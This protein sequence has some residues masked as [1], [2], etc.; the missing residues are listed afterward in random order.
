MKIVPKKWISIILIMTLIMGLASSA[1]PAHVAKALADTQAPTA[2]TNPGSLWRTSDAVHL[3]WTPSTDDTG[4]AAYDIYDGAALVGSTPNGS[5]HYWVTGLAGGSHSFTVKARDAAGNTSAASPS[6]TF[7]GGALD[8]AGWIVSA[9]HRTADAKLAVDHT[10]STRWTTG[11]A[12]GAG[13]WFQIDTGAAPKTYSKLVLEGGG[14]FIRQYS[15]AVSADGTTWGTPIA[16]GSGTAT[17]TVEFAPQTARYIRITSNGANGNYWSIYDLNLFGTWGEDSVPP[18]APVNVQ[19]SA[20]YDAEVQ[21]EWTPSTDNAAVYGYDI[22]AGAQWVVFSSVNSARISGLAANTSYSFTVVALDQAGNA[23]PESQALEVATTGPLN[24]TLWIAKAS[25]GDASAKQ[26]IDASAGTRWT[27]G[28]AQATGMW[29]QVD[30]G[31][32]D[33]AYNKLV[34]DGGGDYPRKYE[35]RV[36][37]DGA[38][39]SEPVAAGTGSA[40][41]MV[42]TFPEQTA[43]FVRIILTG[44]AG[45]YWSIYDLNLY[46]TAAPDTELPS[47]PSGLAAANVLDTQLDLTWNPATD[48]IAVMGYNLYAGT[49]LVTYTTGT[50]W[51]LTGLS[52]A[53]AYSFRVEAVDLAGNRSPLSDALE[54]V[55]KDVIHVPLIARYEMEPDAQNATLLADSSGLGLSGAIAA[56]AA[57]VDGRQGGGKALSLTGADQAKV[58][59]TG[60]LDKISNEMT[61][62]AWIKPQDLNSFQPIVSKRDANW[63]GTTFYLGLEGNKLRFGYDYGEKWNIWSFTSPAIQAGQWFHV[64]VAFE[65]GTGVKFYVNGTLIGSVSPAAAYPGALP[66]DVDMLI[67]TEWHYDSGLRAMIK[68][69]FRGLIDSLRVYGAALTFDQI[70]A[71]KNGTIA[72]RPAEA[73]DFAVPEKYAT[74]RLERFDMPVGLFS[75]ASTNSKT[76]QLAARADGPDAVDWPAITLTIPQADGSAKTVQPFAAGAEYK[77]EIWLQQ[78]PNSMPNLRQPYDNVLN[79]GGHWVRGLYWRWGQTYMYTTDPTARTWGW[80][81]SLWVFPVKISSASAGAVKNVVLK[82]EGTEIYNSGSKTFNSLTLLLPQNEKGKPYELWVDGRGPVAFDAGLKDIEPGNPKDEPIEVDLQLPGSGPAIAVKTLNKPETFPNQAKWNEDAAALSAAKPATPSYTPA[83]GSLQSR[84]GTEVPRS[85]TGVNFIYLPHGMSAGGFF[86]SEHPE[87]AASY[88][89]I[90]SPADYAAYVADTG[91]DRVFE[92][93]NFSANPPESNNHDKVAKELADRGV[94]F[95]L[96]PMT[97]LNYFDLR[98][99]NLPFYTAYLPDFHQPLYR[100]LQ[101]GLQRLGIYPNLAGVSLGADNA[102]YAQYWDWAAPHPNRPWGRAYEQFQTLSGQPLVTPLAPSLQGTYNPKSHEHFAETT[103]AF[104]DYIAR[105]NDTFRNY[106][107]FARAVQAVDPGLAMTTGSFGSSPGVGARGGW[108]WATIPGKE[109]HEEIPVQSAYDWNELASSKPLHQVALLDRLKSYNPVKTTWALQDDF[110]LFFGKADREKTYAMTLT[111]GIQSI[112]TN[113]LPNDRGNVAKPQ[114]IAEQKELYQWIHKYGG[115]YAM[116][117]PEPSIGILYVNEQALL[118]AGYAPDNAG[119]QPTEQGLLN[120]SHEGKVTEALFMTHAA[121]WPSK[122]ITPEELKRGLPSTVKTILLT[123]LNQYDDSWH[124]YD[125]ITAELDAFVEQ[126][127]VIIRDAESVS[128]VASVASGMNIRA[129][130]IQSN[131]DQTRLLLERN[132]DNISIL[133]S[134]MAGKPQ[135][136][137]VSASSTVWAVPTRAGDTRYVTVLNEQHS[138]EPGNEQH[139]VGQTGEIS[140]NTSRPIYDVRLGRQVTQAEASQVDL[141]AH[142]FQWYA[143]PP[144]EVTVP[145]ISLSLGESGFYEAAAMIANPD[146]MTGIPLEWTVAPAGGGGPAAVYS[147]TGLSAQLPLKATDAGGYTVTVKELLSGLSASVQIT[148]PAQPTAPEGS[149]RIDRTEQVLAFTARTG[150]PLTVALTASQNADPAMVAEA[151]RLVQYYAGKGR[152]AALGLAEPGGVVRSLQDYKTYLA[153]P[154]WK[155]EETD[156]ILLGSSATNVLLLDQARGFLLPEQG[157]GLAAGEAAVSY[158]NSAFVGEYDVLNIIANDAAGITAAVN[159]LLALPEAKPQAPQLLQATLRT[160][161]SIGLSWSGEASASGYTV[162]R[163]CNGSPVWETAGTTAQGQISFTDSGLLPDALYTYR[164]RAVGP[165]GVSAPSE[166]ARVYTL[167]ADGGWTLPP[168]PANLAA[169]AHR[170]T[171]IDLAWEPSGG[172]GIAGYEVYADGIKVNATEIAGTAYTV[173]GLNPGVKYVFT[174]RAKDAA[175]NLSPASA[176]QEAATLPGAL[177]RTGW[178]AAASHNAVGAGRAIDAS[179]ATRWDTG[180]NQAAGQYYQVDLGRTAVFNKLVLDASGSSGDYPRGYAV[181]VSADGAVWSAPVASGTGSAVT[182]IPFAEQR[183]RYVRITLTSAISRYWSIH[184]LAI[185]NEDAEAP[186][187]PTSV[188]VREITSNSVLL[189][190]SPSEDNLAVSGYDIYANGI[191][192]NPAA[193]AETAYTAAGLAP[194][195]VYSFTVRARDHAGNVSPDSPAATAKTMDAPLDRTGWTA[196]ASPDSAQANMA[197]DGQRSTVWS[198]VTGQTYGQYY[199]LYLGGERS[200]NQAVLD[201]GEHSGEYPRGYKLYVSGNGED[202]GSPVAEGAWAPVTVIS[203]PYTTA[204]YVRIVQ[205]GTGAAPWT[206]AEINLYRTDNEPPT[207]P[208]GLAASQITETSAHL[209]WQP[210][211]DNGQV[212][213]YRLFNGGEPYG[214]ALIAG[215]SHTV[216]GLVPATGYL[217]QAAAVD[218]AGNVSPLSQPAAFTTK[219]P[220]LDRTGWTATASH[221]PAGAGR[222]LDGNASTRWD[223]VSNQVYGQYF[224]IDMQ[225]SLTFNKLVLDA[226]G[227][228]GDYPRGYSVYVSL[229]G[230]EWGQPVASGSG[231]AVTAIVFPEQTARYIR[232]VQ[233]G[234]VARYWSI[235]EAYVYHIQP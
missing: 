156:L 50:F 3:A 213:G 142:G 155:T 165:A 104:T 115:A 154:Q 176:G 75:S 43:K 29:Y 119:A 81:H 232:V 15:I 14:D 202:W 138:T 26:G 45:V 41:R 211:T 173:T 83:S 174:V 175:G 37:D 177:D 222:A 205:T 33:K 17:L 31:P 196:T 204:S 171:E 160:A 107:Y 98:S 129:Y 36:S 7:V 99:Q 35:I 195:T 62:S 13:M 158:T 102:G 30:T 226:S 206:L 122:V 67:G 161:S 169:V 24:R 23:S 78:S 65:E 56:P 218:A 200:F 164:I 170:E 25:A 85:P 168:A 105:Y 152:S 100:I 220:Y 27:T 5:P 221:N 117:E 90:G 60:L 201:A 11:T 93:A 230:A 72:T 46:G 144:A 131:T 187:A 235:H 52:P 40:S 91:Y 120:A 140:W 123:G 197:L 182:A 214:G 79:P 48:N 216:E 229:D 185:Y 234:A 190:W 135:P 188:E 4:V 141:N 2:P 136:E 184:D 191:K 153:Y 208:A 64:A 179:A 231:S 19:S 212:A 84:I 54:V 16:S 162:E 66:N 113:S 215:T 1:I 59:N 110:S 223:T 55:T 114:M 63:K 193:I 151:N 22:Y 106:G 6:Y 44:A 209:S 203:F 210:S 68:Y 112:G 145:E 225:E 82:S 146:P 207:A 189:V 147:A 166:E 96:I 38:V 94:Q 149:V 92:F 95:G 217:F 137:A 58:A 74:F 53:T 111:R 89:S 124:W 132:A 192:L 116:T 133:R 71:D 134:L 233:T 47:K 178:N 21:L 224:Q 28:A 143:L 10:S 9:S 126:G 8:R 51:Q 69:G 34:L 39:W 49:E 101:L 77:T 97:D 88:Q 180:A 87:N 70:Q 108:N 163:R 125:G 18:S 109:M 186:S 76:R 73:G 32:G 157:N 198:T 61:I 181:A 199:Q 86:H 121:G 57:F 194:S 42:A 228:A 219:E 127:G 130:T 103:K 12:Q 172:E 118:R 148:A 150:K 128:P 227:S 183:A 20:V 159:A 167:R 80:D 139:L